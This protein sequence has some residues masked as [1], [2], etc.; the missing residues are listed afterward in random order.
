M[1]CNR[2]YRNRFFYIMHI[3][4][5][6]RK[7]LSALLYELF[8]RNRKNFALLNLRGVFNPPQFD[9]LLNQ[10][11]SPLREQILRMRPI[12]P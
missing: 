2:I 10:S 7:L 6:I 8:L 1:L 4:N 11:G 3:Y 5:L 9:G 12:G